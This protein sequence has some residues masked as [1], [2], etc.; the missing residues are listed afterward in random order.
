MLRSKILMLAVLFFLLPTISIT[1]VSATNAS[2][3]TGVF[4]EPEEAIHSAYV[5]V[6][7]AEQ[8]G[9]N[10]SVLLDKLN[11]AGDYL[12]E[13]YFWYH[14]GDSVTANRFAGM[15]RDAVVN[16]Q[17]EALALMDAAKA[18]GDAEFVALVVESIVGVVAVVALCSV[19]WIIF[20]R[21]YHGQ[22][23]ELTSEVD[24]IES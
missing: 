9:A 22:V 15:S 6:L 21:R 11:L 14:S 5:A 13:A 3:V 2:A 12:S 10:V 23:L 20:K 18:D 7:D 4:I 19:A 8:A 17:N 1:W 16:V 24:S